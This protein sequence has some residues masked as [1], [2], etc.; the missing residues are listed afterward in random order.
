MKDLYT[1]DLT[2]SEAVETYR[3][4]SGA[5]RAFFAELKLPYL[6]AEASS[7]A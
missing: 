7:G 3:Q 2:T 1:F 6:I 4:V 5:Y